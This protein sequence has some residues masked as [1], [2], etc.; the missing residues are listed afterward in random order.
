[1][2]KLFHIILIGLLAASCAPQESD[3]D[4]L[5]RLNKDGTVAPNPDKPSL[6]GEEEPESG[7]HDEY[8]ETPEAREARL[9]R[10]GQTPIRE[11]YYTEYTDKNL[12]PKL[13]D[14][15]CFTHVNVGHGRFVNKLTGEGLEI[16]SETKR[17]LTEM[18][19]FKAQYPELKV[20]LMIGGWGKNAN[21]F[22]PM[23]ADPE[24]RAAFVANV[25]AAIEEYHLD[26]VDIDWEY[27]T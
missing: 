24:K 13:A 18:V 20:K 1:M 16:P 2:N 15:R 6:P 21:G 23:A 3:K 17:L 11:V 19:A 7:E 25:K 4:W 27:P 5:S 9:A 10:L 12:F 26:G 14:I 22:S 8:P